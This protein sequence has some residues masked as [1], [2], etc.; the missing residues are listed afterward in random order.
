[1]ADKPTETKHAPEAPKTSNL[2]RVLTQDGLGLGS[3]NRSMNEMLE[4]M[5]KVNGVFGGA[6]KHTS[7]PKATIEKDGTISVKTTTKDSESTPKEKINGS[8]GS[9][10]PH[11]RSDS[12][13]SR[14]HSR[15]TEATMGASDRKRAEA[16]AD[17]PKESKKFH[18]VLDPSKPDNLWQASKERG[19]VRAGAEKTVKALLGAIG[20][21]D[22][23]SLGENGL[24]NAK[25]EKG[26]ILPPAPDDPDQVEINISDTIQGRLTV[27]PD[28]GITIKKLPGDSSIGISASKRVIDF[29]FTDK[30]IHSPYA[31]ITEV[32]LKKGDD[33]AISAIP[34]ILH[35][36]WGLQEQDPVPLST[37]NAGVFVGLASKCD[38]LGVFKDP[39]AKPKPS[40]INS[41][42]AENFPIR[43]LQ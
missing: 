24:F 8:D 34:T 26:M 30:D 33:G 38:A 6:E 19:M 23:L 31:D 15:S 32:T 17:A 39:I 5:K 21:I 2:E 12:R 9:T 41:N 7:Y 1:M 13:I 37:K 25:L 40:K 4:G 27:N 20:G 10:Q 36:L 35:P 11:T 29:P 43:K 22:K 14:S 3:M 18:T 42:I 28:G 16:H